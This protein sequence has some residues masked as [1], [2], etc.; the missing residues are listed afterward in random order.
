MISSESDNESNFVYRASEIESSHNDSGSNDIHSSE[1]ERIETFLQEISPDSHD[2]LN[3]H[4][5]APKFSNK[6]K[7][8]SLEQDF[9]VSIQAPPNKKLKKTSKKRTQKKLKKRRIKIKK[10]IV[11][12][13]KDETEQSKT[14]NKR[15]S[16]QQETKVKDIIPKDEDGESSDTEC[17]ICCSRYLPIKW[18]Q[19]E[20]CYEWSHMECLDVKDFKRYTKNPRRRWTCGFC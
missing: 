17:A 3:S 13:E 14:R 7:F 5:T 8:E 19:C 15:K 20:K 16:K 11:V 18:I 10:T 12:K 9:S 1:I 6:R 4:A 2:S